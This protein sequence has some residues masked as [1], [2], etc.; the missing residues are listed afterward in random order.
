MRLKVQLG[1][2]VVGT[3]AAMMAPA[4]VRAYRRYN[5]RTKLAVLN[6]RAPGSVYNDNVMT[7]L[8]EMWGRSH[9]PDH[10][11]MPNRR[12][13]LIGCVLRPSASPGLP[14]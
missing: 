5:Q 9:E 11:S 12:A 3:T 1:L 7:M 4:I 14:T 6:P 13:P 10:P 8:R 2:A